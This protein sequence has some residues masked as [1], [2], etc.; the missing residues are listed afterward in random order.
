MSALTNDFG[1]RIPTPM[2]VL[3]Q[4][5]DK[6]S[7]MLRVEKLTI[8]RQS[9]KLEVVGGYDPDS[10]ERKPVTFDCV[11]LYKLGNPGASF[12]FSFNFK[13]LPANQHTV[14]ATLKVEQGAGVEYSKEY[15]VQE[16][17]QM[18]NAYLGS[19]DGTL[20]AFTAS[21]LN[22][23]MSG[24][25]QAFGIILSRDLTPA[26]VKAF[27]AEYVSKVQDLKKKL[28]DHTNE[29]EKLKK[30][31]KMLTDADRQLMT[32][33]VDECSLYATE[34]NQL[35]RVGGKNIPALSREYALKELKIDTNYLHQGQ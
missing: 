5:L 6:L 1:Q 34:L 19:Q 15:S 27:K 18:L 22:V 24:F 31:G 8:N 12:S 20:K 4:H 7:A 30:K 23:F 26:Q 35:L 16:M 3:S 29:Y 11:Y 9:Y 10:Y 2:Q 14:R 25:A 28:K 33:L 32:K 17:K 21:T 13:D